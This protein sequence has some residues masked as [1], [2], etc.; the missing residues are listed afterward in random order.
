MGMYDDI[1]IKDQLPLN[2]E[3]IDFGFDH[4]DSY[5]QTKDLECAMAF[6]KIENGELFIEKFA[7]TEWIE[8]NK[9]SKSIME[10]IG[11]FKRE[12]PYFEKIPHHGD[13]GFYDFYDV[14]KGEKTYEVWVEFNARFGNGKVEK[15]DLVKFEA[16]DVTERLIAEEKRNEEYRAKM[17]RPV[18]KYFLN[19][20]WFG[21]LKRKWVSFWSYI[22]LGFSKMASLCQKIGYSIYQ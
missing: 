20:R 10:R 19:A 12:E 11:Y 14:K 16:R 1:S 18:Y 13:I 4:K 5:F 9:N 8:G 3:M 6:Y 22:A 21:F 17:E 15:I 7:K 2:Q